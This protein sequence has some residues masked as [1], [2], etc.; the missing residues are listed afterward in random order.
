MFL[1]KIFESLISKIISEIS[2]H[3]CSSININCM[4]EVRSICLCKLLASK[5]IN[6]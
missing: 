4:A 5:N 6:F 3:I 1:N 2:Q